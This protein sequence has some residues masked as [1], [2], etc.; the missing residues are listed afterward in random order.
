MAQDR[1]ELRDLTTAE[2]RQAFI[3][4]GLGS[5]T[6]RA[7]ILELRSPAYEQGE[8]AIAWIDATT[9]T[10]TWQMLSEEGNAELE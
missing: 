5:E 9:G 3:E 4:M 6:E 10:A 8:K 7:K 2:I 1:Q